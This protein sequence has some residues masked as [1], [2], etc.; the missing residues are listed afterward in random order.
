M[1]SMIGQIGTVPTPITACNN[2]RIPRAVPAGPVAPRGSMLSGSPRLAAPRRAWHGLQ[3]PPAAAPAA[4]APSMATGSPKMPRSRRTAH[5]MVSASRRSAARLAMPHK[6][7]WVPT[8]LVTSDRRLACRP[9]Q[10]LE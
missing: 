9:L 4:P 3:T 8:L 1:R 7:Q 2:G 10:V 6:P 5:D